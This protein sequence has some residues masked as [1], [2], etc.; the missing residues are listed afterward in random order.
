MLKR[1]IVD[2]DQVANEGRA[3]PVHVALKRI[4]NYIQVHFDPDFPEKEFVQWADSDTEK[5]LRH[6]KVLYYWEPN[7]VP[8]RDRK[9]S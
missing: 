9:V 2:I 8:L 1:Y 5:P 3:I 6:N 7:D 4:A